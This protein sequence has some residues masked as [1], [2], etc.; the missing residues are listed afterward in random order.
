MNKSVIAVA[1]TGALGVAA[2]AATVSEFANG[3]L[4]PHVLDDVDNNTQTAIGL[5]SCAA[6]V[7]YWTFFDVNTKHVLDDQFPV[8]ANDQINM[9]WNQSLNGG[10]DSENSSEDGTIF[11]GAGLENFRGY[12]LFILD[13]TGDRA[14]NGPLT[15]T[16][17]TP[18][19][20][21]NAFQI[22]L[23]NNDVIYIPT[24]PTSAIAGDFTE[25]GE[26]L[27]DDFLIPNLE[28]VSSTDLWDLAAGARAG[29]QIYMRYFLDNAE[30]TIVTWSAQ[31]LPGPR[32]VNLYNTQQNRRSVTF[33]PTGELSVDDPRGIVGRPSEFNDGFIVYPV[34]SDG[35]VSFSLIDADAFGAVQ[36]VMNPIRFADLDN[37]GLPGY[38]QGP[39]D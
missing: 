11:G 37:D 19:L 25:P 15:A 8:T 34:P 33:G 26:A 5:T 35:V 39:V 10:A 16:S 7:V 21:G 1:L 30:T 9:V 32:T 12:L 24:L 29:D 20:A 18:C 6:G 2:H 28:D 23:G 13:T 4:V 38:R 31:L 27:T 17:D 14:L 22:D 36:T 3:V